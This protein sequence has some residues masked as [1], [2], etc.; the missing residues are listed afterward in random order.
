MVQ[1][2]GQDCLG[3][4]LY[5]EATALTTGADGAIYVAGYTEGNLDGQINSGSHDAFLTKYN[6][7]G[8]KAWTR[9]LGTTASDQATALT[10][11]VDGA[12]YVAGYTKGNLDGQI[13]SGGG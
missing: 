13:N 4:V 2:L 10:T 7:D 6:T 12:I 11:G 8:T 9:L 3:R 5:D 1:K